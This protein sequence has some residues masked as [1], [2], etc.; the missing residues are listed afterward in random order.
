M[1]ETPKATQAYLWS[2]PLDLKWL[3]PKKVVDR[4]TLNGAL[5]SRG[6]GE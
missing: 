5:G 2:K 6:V 3:T 1:G 4:H